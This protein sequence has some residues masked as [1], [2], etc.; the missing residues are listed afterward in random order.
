MNAAWA[1]GA[2]TAWVAGD[3]QAMRTRYSRVCPFQWFHWNPSTLSATLDTES[4]STSS[5]FNF[6]VSST[7]A[8]RCG[9]RLSEIRR[10]IGSAADTVCRRAGQLHHLVTGSSSGSGCRCVHDYLMLDGGQ[11]AE[12]CLLESA[13]GR[14]VVSTEARRWRDRR[15]FPKKASAALSHSGR[16]LVGPARLGPTSK[17]AKR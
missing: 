10:H 11:A 16:T 12:L 14:A 3:R 7:A 1:S 17:P 15:A 8:S 2:G 6:R 4:N 5:L 9:A 13:T